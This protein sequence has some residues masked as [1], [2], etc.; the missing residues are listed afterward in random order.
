MELLKVQHGA[1]IPQA[2]KIEIHFRP[3]R[4]ATPRPQGVRKTKVGIEHGGSVR[5]A[6]PR[7]WRSLAQGRHDLADVLPAGND[8][9]GDGDADQ[10]DE[11]SS[12]G[13]RNEKVRPTEVESDIQ[14]AP[15][16]LELKAE[17]QKKTPRV[18]TLG[19]APPGLDPEAAKPLKDET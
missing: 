8:A 6:E 15:L 9:E 3:K 19:I 10:A 4:R 7:G 17:P 14:V 18:F 5:P 13:R 16:G 12:D 2:E 1:P 11:P